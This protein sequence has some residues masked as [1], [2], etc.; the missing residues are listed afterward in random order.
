MSFSFIYGVECDDTF[1]KG[2]KTLFV[3]GLPTIADI[4]AAIAREERYNSK[5]NHIVFGSSTS[6]NINY[7]CDTINNAE[8]EI[9]ESTIHH[10]LEKSY[11]CSLEV[12]FS[13]MDIIL[14]S[15]L[16]EHPCFIPKITLVA[17]YIRQ[18]RDNG[19]FKIIDGTEDD[20]INHGTWSH[21]IDDLVSHRHFINTLDKDRK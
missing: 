15:R 8:L 18:L 14:E 20:H 19:C 7:D 12:D 16:I 13:S 10:Y 9:W 17:P 11:W 2:L 5:I 3:C 4:D 1:A 21:R 6:F